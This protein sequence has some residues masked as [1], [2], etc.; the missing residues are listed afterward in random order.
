MQIFIPSNIIDWNATLDVL[1]ALKLSGH[2]ETLTE[3][4]NL[5]DESYKTGEIQTEEEY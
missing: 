1:L 4:S 2:T 3:A 5:I